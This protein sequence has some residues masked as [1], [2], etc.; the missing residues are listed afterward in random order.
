MY[1]E[2]ERGPAYANFLK[3]ALEEPQIVGVHWF[4]Y[5]DQPVTGRLLD[6]ENGHLG[7]VAITDRP[8]DGFVS[9]VRKANLSV[10]PVVLEQAAQAPQP[11]PDPVPAQ[12]ATPA[13]EP[14]ADS[15]APAAQPKP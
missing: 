12:G 1:K 4:Q 13:T 7:L 14:A 6:G 11:E 3:K 10:P 2:E 5:L 15:A 9:A 8:W